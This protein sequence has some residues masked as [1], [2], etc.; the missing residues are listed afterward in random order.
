MNCPSCQATLP[1]R[2]N[3]CGFCGARL[4][5]SA[6]APASAEAQQ[7]AP[8][9]VHSPSGHLRGSGYLPPLPG[10]TRAAALTPMGDRRVVT[11]L[12]TDVSGFTAM[13]ERLDP[14]E[15]REI[16]NSFFRVLSEPIY[17]YGG[18]VDKYIGDA[19]MAI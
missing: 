10:D 4:A 18:I 2:A 5:E 7:F 17:R 19:I 1:Q 8:P 15:V 6:V 3:F 9:P 13:S 16:V 14:E 11:V 12:F